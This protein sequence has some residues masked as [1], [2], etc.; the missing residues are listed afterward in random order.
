[1]LKSEFELLVRQGRGNGILLLKKEADKSPFRDM[2]IFAA[3]N[4]L[5]YDWQC[6][7][8]QAWYVYELI[9]CFDDVDLIVAAIISR[10]KEIS[11]SEY[12]CTHYLKMLTIFSQNGY[13]D[14]ADVIMQIYDKEYNIMAGRTQNSDS[15]DYGRD[16]YGYTAVEAIYSGCI[17]PYRLFCDIGNLLLKD[18]IFQITDF[19]MWIDE[20]RIYIGDTAFDS[21][22]T[23]DNRDVIRFKSA[24]KAEKERIK[25]L[26]IR[27]T[28]EM[29][30]FENVNRLI[31]YI[32]E[33]KP[34]NYS[35]KKYL[36]DPIESKQII[37]LSKLAYQ[38][39]D[40]ERKTVL[41]S[42]LPFMAI[43]SDKLIEEAC[44]YE[45]ALKNPDCPEYLLETRILEK[46]G[47][48]FN[49]KPDIREYARKLVA[50]GYPDSI[51]VG[52]R[53]QIYELSDHDSF[54]KYIKGIP[55]ERSNSDIWHKADFAVLGMWKHKPDIAPAE[56]IYYIYET[57]LCAACRRNAVKIINKYGLMT[58]EICD[59]ARYDSEE[60]VRNLVMNR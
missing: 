31:T 49:D 9:K 36:K 59:E 7:D 15:Y 10:Y 37:E 44:K 5:R 25:H 50:K 45:Y 11:E 33:R 20:V 58:S 42:I 21:V 30:T 6:S 27:W 4:D 32:R 35:M 19:Y 1:M 54:V 8:D 41:Y 23:W 56:L 47:N 48:I 53:A 17:T 24:W 2:V 26:R 43:S 51:M 29:T 57:T 22:L 13:S 14:A 39:N 16:K 34:V 46:L 12:G 40:V 28:S 55:V 38:E 3:I 52:L 18:G 60:D